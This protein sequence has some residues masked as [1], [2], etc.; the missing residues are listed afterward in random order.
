MEPTA[1][2]LAGGFGTRLKSVVKEVPKPMAPVAGRPFL[3]Y[4]LDTLSQT[5]VTNVILGVGYK[6][7]VIKNHFGDRYKNLDLKYV[8]ED[9]PL[10]TGGAIKK[11]LLN[12]D[13]D[14]ALIFNGDTLYK[15]N[16]NHFIENSRGLISMA[17]KFIDNNH[18]YGCVSFRGNRLTG[19]NE[20]PI[21]AKSGYINA[22]VYLIE[23]KLLDTP[24]FQPEVF[25]F[26]KDVL[27]KIIKD[28]MIQVYPSDHYFID[29]GIPE[30]YKQ[31]NK[32]FLD[33]EKL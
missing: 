11:A 6:H 16:L 24:Y 25:S 18:R 29:I 19:F 26:E 27:E 23:N 10:G 31:A 15:L 9:K 8:I 14:K 1:I 12:I 21:K 28:E 7:E 13:S 33:F 30:D 5:N 4:I 3:E 2:I 17:L 32:D 22:G 20:K